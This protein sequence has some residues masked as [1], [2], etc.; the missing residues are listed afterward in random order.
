MAVHVARSNTSILNSRR[1]RRI[2]Y[3]GTHDAKRERRLVVTP[4]SE[5][6]IKSWPNDQESIDEKAAMVWRTATHVHYNRDLRFNSQSLI[7][8]MTERKCIRRHGLA[9]GHLQD[10][11][12]SMRCRCGAIRPSGCFSLVGH[13]QD[14]R[15]PRTNNS[16]GRSPTSQPSTL[17]P[18][19]T[20]NT[21]RPSGS[22][23]CFLRSGF[24]LLTR[25]MR[26]RLGL[27]WTGRCWL[28]FWGFLRLWWRT[29]GRL[30]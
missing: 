30:I 13:Q 1:F 11:S 4:D 14:A 12:T 10:Q 21:P 23:T 22:L 7:V 28:M 29:M 27:D 24:F 3:C 2:Q 26:I 6:Q 5:G 17:A 15:W 20:L 19:P 16:H 18:L 9:I 8:A 25:L